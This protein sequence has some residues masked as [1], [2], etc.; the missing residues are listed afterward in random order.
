MEKTPAGPASLGVF[1]AR[2]PHRALMSWA[3]EG[4]RRLFNLSRAVF[5]ICIKQ[6]TLNR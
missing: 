4:A 1:Y 3:L 5:G 2:L 6:L